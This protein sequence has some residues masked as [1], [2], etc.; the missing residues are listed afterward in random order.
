V[1]T[2]TGSC[3]VALGDIC[4]GAFTNNQPLAQLV[5]ADFTNALNKALANWEM[6]NS[7]FK[8]SSALISKGVIS[9][10]EFDVITA[11]AKESA[12][13]KKDLDLSAIFVCEVCGFTVEAAAPDKCPLCGAPMV[14]RT[15]QYGPFLGCS[16]Y[17][18]CK[19]TRRL[20]AAG[21]PAT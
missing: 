11:R 5:Q 3:R 14:R 4:T 18:R 1:A 13:A 10:N 19:G 20:P 6:D 12:E 16:T 17:P 7:L 9:S 15:S 21:M 8:R 2:L